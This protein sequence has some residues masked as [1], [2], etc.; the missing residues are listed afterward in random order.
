MLKASVG[1]AV[2][3]ASGVVVVVICTVAVS[4]EVGVVFDI[5]GGFVLVVVI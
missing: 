2:V 5:V 4:T 3:T 1:R